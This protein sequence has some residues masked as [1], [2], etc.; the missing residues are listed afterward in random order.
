MQPFVTPFFHWEPAPGITIEPYL[1]IWDSTSLPKQE[2]RLGTATA[3]A[4]T[5]HFHSPV[6]VQ[7]ASQAAPATPEQPRSVLKLMGG[8]YLSAGDLSADFKYTWY[9]ASPFAEFAPIQE[10]GVK[11]AYDVLGAWRDPERSYNFGLK[12]YGAI[13]YE[14]LNSATQEGTYAETGLEPFVQCCLC[15]RKVGISLPVFV[16]LSVDNYFVNAAGQNEPFGYVS[17]GMAVSM[18]IFPAAKF[19]SWF[20]TVSAQY[21]YLSAESLRIANGGD[22]NAFIGKVGIGFSY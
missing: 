16:G 14:T 10:V 6:A 19:G 3:V 4:N 8:T 13:Y 20:C 12:P 22:P 11:L 1:S 17:G 9:N 5:G 18:P 2:Q 21:M 7:P 15:G